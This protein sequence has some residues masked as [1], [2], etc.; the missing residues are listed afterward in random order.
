MTGRASSWLEGNRLRDSVIVVGL[1]GNLG[2]DEAV[3]R[4]CVDAIA[5]LSEA[6]GTA[7]VSSFWRTAPVG[8][9]QAQPDFVNAVA[10]WLPSPPVSPEQAL[11]ALQ[12][13]EHIHGRE[14]AVAGGPRSLDLDLL[15][16]GSEHR[17]Q[18]ALQLPHPRMGR[19]AFVLRPLAELFGAEFRWSDEVSLGELM[20]APE[21]ARQPC[22]RLETRSTPHPDSV[23]E[24]QVP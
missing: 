7:R 16:V 19:R 22:E 9:V 15:L 12:R 17:R 11:A 6:W 4:R 3:K 5:A 24:G 1:G 10:A 23:N 2:G 20:A 8:A 14:R 21:V 13:L 18:E